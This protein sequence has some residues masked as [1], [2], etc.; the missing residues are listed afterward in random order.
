MYMLRC[1]THPKVK[2]LSTYLT[3]ESLVLAGCIVALSSF[4]SCFCF[5]FLGVRFDMVSPCGLWY[6]NSE[7]KS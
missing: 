4:M 6:L 2:R 7:R 3:I 1:L 5:C